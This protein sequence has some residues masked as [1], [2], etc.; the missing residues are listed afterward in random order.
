[1]FTTLERFE[2]RPH[3]PE[4]KRTSMT[5]TTIWHR[6]LALATVAAAAVALSGCT[7]VDQV[8][9]EISNAVDSGDGTTKNIFDISVGDCE[10]DS[11]DEGER[12]ET[13][14]IDCAEPHN[15]E[16]YASVNVPDGDFPGDAAI[17]EQATTDCYTEFESFIGANYDDSDYDF[18][19]YFPTEGSWS[20]GDREI[21]CLVYDV[22]G[23]Q[24]SGSLAGVAR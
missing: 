11:I 24:V 15:T 4:K 23:A 21:L 1:M 8:T 16:I 7:V 2:A 14:T 9:T 22:S 10:I 3:S 19:W 20:E 13:T 5:T 18:S 17:D 6:T 12:F